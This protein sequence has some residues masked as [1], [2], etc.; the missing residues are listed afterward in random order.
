MLHDVTATPTPFVRDL[1][2]PR[3]GSFLDAPRECPLNG[4]IARKCQACLEWHGRVALL[5]PSEEEIFDA[6]PELK[7]R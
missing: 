6:E 1:L 3:C 7:P 2:C 4:E 5:G